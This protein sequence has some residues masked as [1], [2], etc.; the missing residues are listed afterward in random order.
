[1]ICID[2]IDTGDIKG[3]KLEAQ[4]KEWIKEGRD[5]LVVLSD[6]EIMYES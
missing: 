4:L 6:A 1:M 3:S 2:C 5:V